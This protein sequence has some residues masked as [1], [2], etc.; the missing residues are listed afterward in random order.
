M[1][2]GA[3]RLGAPERAQG[4]LR[5]PERPGTIPRSLGMVPFSHCADTNTFMGTLQPS[6][7]PR[8]SLP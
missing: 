2:D 3:T 1:G 5:A 6:L 7:P 8:P 4:A